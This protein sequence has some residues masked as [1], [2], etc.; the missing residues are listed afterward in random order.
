[1][2]EENDA[3]LIEAASKGDLEKLQKLMSGEQPTETTVQR[4][5][6][7]AAW[8]SQ[9]PIIKFLLSKYPPCSIE[10]EAVRAGI[11]SGSI[12]LFSALLSTDPSIINMQFDMRGTPLIVACMSQKP[13][14]FLK[15]LLESGADP[16]QDPD[17]AMFPP[18]AF[19]AAFYQDCEAVDLLLKHGARLEHS[20]ALAA[21]AGRN[22]E[23]ML[24]YLLERGADHDDDRIGR[25]EPPK[26]DLALHIAA[27][28]GYLGVV[29]ILL[30]HGVDPSVKD[31]VGNTAVQIIE[32]TESTGKDLF[33]V[34]ELFGRY[35]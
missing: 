5:L 35:K 24:R 32:E 4:L 8:K 22:N 1:M 15:F 34:R 3:C 26:A 23:A 25:F 17:A 19:V 13:P 30:A 18:L 16:N 31:G 9:T 14:E 6:A 10:E 27:K 33:E 28:K 2:N 7:A 12:P 11:Y 21:A 29:K 20:G